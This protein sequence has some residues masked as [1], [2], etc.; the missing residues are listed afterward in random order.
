MSPHTWRRYRLFAPLALVIVASC[1]D[2][3]AP[4]RVP[5]VKPHFAQGDNGVWTV[6]SKADPG[7]GGCDDTECTLRE[8]M[9][10]SLEGDDI[11]FAAG[12]QGTIKLA[13]AIIFSGGNREVT[14]DGDKRIAVEAAFS[15]QVFF[16]GDGATLELNGLQLTGSG[17]FA[18]NGGIIY[19]EDA[20]KVEVSNS[21]LNLGHSNI[22]G[23]AIYNRGGKL[24]VRNSTF[25]ANQAVN[26]G[27]VYNT[28]N[29]TATITGTEF[30]LNTATNVGG[31]IGHTASTTLSVI[32]STISSNTA[33]SGAGFFL[34]SGSATIALSTISGN[35]ATAIGAGGG[36]TTETL[37]NLDLRS[38][39]ITRNKSPLGGGGLMT[40]GTSRVANSI[41]AGNTLPDCDGGEV[42]LGHNLTTTTGGCTLS[43][44]GDVK[45]NAAVVHTEVLEQDLKDN[46][47]PLKTH[48]LIARGRAVDVGYCPG[49]SADQ[50]GF[51]RP[52]DD[53]VMPNAIDACDIG[54]YERQGPVVATADLMV[55]QTVDKAS[56]KQGDLLTYYVRVQNLGP[57]TA[58]NVVLS[59]VLSPGA[60]FYGVRVGKGTV[61]APPRGETGTVTWTIGDLLSGE[62]Q[63]ADIQV[64]VLVKGKTTITNTATVSGNVSDPN[65]AND[66]AAITVSVAAGTSAKPRK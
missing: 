41:I 16:V 3:T 30:L 34:G 8:A 25:I 32:G 9:S 55:S 51:A 31:A 37:A 62:N 38:S 21:L 17:D 27:A 19:A 66:S 46:G 35:E 61:K 24:V 7:A 63:V 14:I 29:G 43:G 53:P 42:S 4:A 52:V 49:E 20:T 45:V 47:G 40:F 13:D 48:A 10:A 28:L 59:N 39:T 6:N 15:N 58:P 18:G 65:K 44:S 57:Q 26:G 23:G 33:L 22:N 2:S 60:T 1:Q 11:V 56:V 50:R 36:I 54:A 64:T 5:A 12:L